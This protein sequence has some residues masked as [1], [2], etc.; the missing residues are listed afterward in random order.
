MHSTRAGEDG[1]VTAIPPST[2]SRRTVLGATAAAIGLTACRTDADRSDQADAVSPSTKTS[3]TPS[4]TEPIAPTTGD[5]VLHLIRRATYGSRPGLRD[6]IDRIGLAAWLDD[7]LQAVPETHAFERS[8]LDAMPVLEMPAPDL[9]DRVQDT[10]AP[11]QLGIQLVF[12]TLT[13]QV[14]S[15][16]QLH[17]RMVEFWSDH[18]N[19]PITDQTSIPLKI[20]DHRSVARPFALGRFDDLLVASATSPAMLRYLDN[21]GSFRGAINENY[22]RELL[23]LHTVGVDGGYD[24]ADIVSVARLLTGWTVD[25][26]TVEFR[27]DRDRHDDGAVE[28]LG[29]NRPD[30]GDP[31]AHGE[32]FLRY[33][34]THPSTADHVCRKLA[35][36]FVADDPPSDIID[37]MA[38][39]WVAEG[40]DIVPVLR[41]MF[42][43]DSFGSTPAK[44]QRPWDHLVQTLRALG[45]SPSVDADPA[46]L[47]RLAAAVQEVGQTPYRWPAP[48]GYPDVESAWHDAGGILTRW[49]ATAAVVDGITSG[50]AVFPAP[51]LPT[52][53][54]LLADSA[55]AADVVTAIHRAVRGETPSDDRVAALLATAGWASTDPVDDTALAAASTRLLFSVLADPSASYR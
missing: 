43:H 39:T 22:A 52:S 10:A 17:E 41:T 9:V 4:T 3:A 24:E 21:A 29:W 20:V 1:T 23:E 45:A 50:S 46:T 11:A 14:A 37:A 19:V 26:R 40:S 16:F 51:D 8:L 13:R 49:R 47:R 7:Q 53:E 32:Q 38:R 34:A 35:R 5:P 54:E 18:L 28:V 27:F 55:G 36:R 2:V 30:G 12:A 31:R 25:R 42:E 44:F 33:L 48:N 6:E 15:P